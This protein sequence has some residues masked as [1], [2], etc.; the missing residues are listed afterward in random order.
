MNTSQEV[1]SRPFQD[2][3]PNAEWNV[4]AC[5]TLRNRLASVSNLSRDLVEFFDFLNTTFQMWNASV[6]CNIHIHSA[7][8]LV[9]AYGPSWK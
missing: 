2:E 9:D 5:E 4:Q 8:I 7:S 3:L 1:E 6:Y